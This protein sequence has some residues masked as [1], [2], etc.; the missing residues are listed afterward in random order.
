MFQDLQAAWRQET[1]LETQVEELTKQNREIEQEIEDLAPGGPGIEKRARQDLG[2]SKEGEIVI[3]I[4][5]KK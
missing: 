2:W 5:D 4:P 3:R 1:E